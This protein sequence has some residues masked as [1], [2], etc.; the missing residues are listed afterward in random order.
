MLFLSL[1]V[2]SIQKFLIWLFLIHSILSFPSCRYTRC[3]KWQSIEKSQE[4]EFRVLTSYIQWA[5]S[6]T[7]PSLCGQGIPVSKLETELGPETQQNKGLPCSFPS[8]PSPKS[9][10]LFSYLSC[11]QTRS[12]CKRER[13]QS[14]CPSVW[15]RDGRRPPTEVSSNRTALLGHLISPGTLWSILENSWGFCFV[16]FF[17]FTYSQNNSI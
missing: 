12:Q 7:R 5:T 16:F 17:S 1:S 6:K 4:T 8:R 3:C 13:A 11:A 10:Y 9:Q 14:F 15:N 2:I